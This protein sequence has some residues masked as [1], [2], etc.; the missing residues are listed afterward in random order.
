M[1]VSPAAMDMSETAKPVLPQ[2]MINKVQF[3]VVLRTSNVLIPFVICFIRAVF[4]CV[5]LLGN[6]EE[7]AE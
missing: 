3:L 6:Y 2:I 4:L 5:G 1:Q 7:D